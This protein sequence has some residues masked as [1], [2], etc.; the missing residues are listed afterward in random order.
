M[1]RVS[2]YNKY[3]YYK[4]FTNDYKGI[5]LSEATRLR[6]RAIPEE[7]PAKLVWKMGVSQTRAQWEL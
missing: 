4:S 1:Y 3:I 6:T 5:E 2:E 7:V